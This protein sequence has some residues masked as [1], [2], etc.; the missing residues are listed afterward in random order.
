MSIKMNIIQQVSIEPIT[1][2]V[3]EQWIREKIAEQNPTINVDKVEFIQKRTPSRIEV[4]VTASFGENTHLSLDKANVVEP[5]V[6]SNA[7]QTAVEKGGTMAGTPV[8]DNLFPD[9]N[10]EEPS[11]LDS[12]ASDTA[13]IDEV[14]GADSGAG[15][16]VA[17]MF[18]LPK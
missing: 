9:A 18:N 14:L 6:L 7:I 17:D 5:E 2:E 13:I 8:E 15:G 10:A 3:L 11:V 1:Q 4:E 16:D 12:Q